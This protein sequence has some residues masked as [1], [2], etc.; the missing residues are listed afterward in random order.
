MGSAGDNSFMLLAQDPALVVAVDI[1]TAQLMLIALKKAAI[2]ILDEKDLLAFLGVREMKNRTKWMQDVFSVLGPSEKIYWEERKKQIGSGIIHAGKFERYFQLFRKYILAWIH[3]KKT[4]AALLSEKNAE[5]QR[6]FYQTTWNTWQW[7]MLF[8][9]FF[10][11][12]VMG[13]AGR[14][15]SFLQ[16]VQ[17]PVS[18]YVFDKAASHLSSV[19]SQQNY[20]LQYILTGNFQDQL[21]P[22][23]YPVN[24]EKIRRNLH[25]LEICQGYLETALVRHGAFDRFNLSDIFEYMDDIQFQ[26][27]A[28]N[29]ALHAHQ[30]AIIA[31]WNL[32]VPRKLSSAASH[33]FRE[34][35]EISDAYN[36]VDR[37]FFYNRFQVDS[38][39]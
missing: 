25:K 22:Y 14:D 18:R 13:R 12:S 31:Y 26:Q 39:L 35:T 28:E 6:I 32:M 29:I 30:N 38:R 16:E 8:R 37:G 4:I 33:L 34:I 23:L 20:M 7:R 2:S 11:K 15:P 17:I 10:S 27:I 36:K 1:N 9:I 3:N 5:E 19:R 24:L 21:P